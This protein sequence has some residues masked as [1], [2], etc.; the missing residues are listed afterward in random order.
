MANFY[1]S[2]T[3]QGLGTIA[4][5]AVPD[6]AIYSVDGKMTLPTI[7]QGSAAPS[8]LVVVVNLDGSPVYTG[9]A[10]SEVSTRK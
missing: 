6:T 4:S 5:F 7:T 2:L 1:K 8:A 9:T 3:A 10:G